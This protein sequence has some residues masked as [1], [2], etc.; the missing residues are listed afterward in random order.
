MHTHKTV[1][2]WMHALV[3]ICVIYDRCLALYICSQSSLYF[4]LGSND[5][6]FLIRCLCSSFSSFLSCVL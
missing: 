5:I 6:L 2:E 3:V 1:I 4:L